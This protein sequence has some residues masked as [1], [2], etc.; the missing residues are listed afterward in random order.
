MSANF[1]SWAAPGSGG[2]EMDGLREDIRGAAFLSVHADDERATFEDVTKGEN[3]G[4]AGK[5]NGLIRET[6]EPV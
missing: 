6:P 2:R 5:A 4:V 1:A 3:K